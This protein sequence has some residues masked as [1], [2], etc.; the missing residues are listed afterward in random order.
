MPTTPPSAEKS[1]W[2]RVVGN[3]GNGLQSVMVLVRQ[4]DRTGTPLD[5][6]KYPF[7][8]GLT[9]TDGWFGIKCNYAF[10]ADIFLN[11]RSYGSYWCENGA[12]ITITV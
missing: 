8:Q 2:I 9:N 11:N 12:R 1:F 4:T 3:T 6:N 7:V 10:K 5:G